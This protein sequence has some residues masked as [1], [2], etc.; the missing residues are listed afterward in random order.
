MANYWSNQTLLSSRVR[1]NPYVRD[2]TFLPAQAAHRLQ[3]V[4]GSVTAMPLESNQFDVAYARFLFQHLPDPRAAVQE[5]WRVLKPGGKLIISDIDDA[6]FGLFQPDLPEFAPILAAF[7]D[8]QAARGGNRH[9]GRQLWPILS[10]AG[11][12]NGE[13]EVIGSHS[14]E[15][16]ITSFLQHIDPDRLQSLVQHG[17]V[18][19]AEFDRYRDALARFAAAPE[20][21]TLWLSILVCGEKPHD[22]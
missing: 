21:Y 7:G 12:C 18:A 19:A 4:E 13:V 16:G 22:G 20:A 1:K 8:V 3:F 11:F 14:A 2:L 10:A 17:Y 6:L 5:I 15:R 9:I